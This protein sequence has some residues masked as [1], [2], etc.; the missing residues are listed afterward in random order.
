MILIDGLFL[1]DFIKL[2]DTFLSTLRFSLTDY[3]SEDNRHV[4][5]WIHEFSLEDARSHPLLSFVYSRIRSATERH[6]LK[7]E[8]SSKGFIATLLS[9]GICSFHTLIL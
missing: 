2:F 8:S 1:P 6:A 5:H 4:R 3:D 9:T 7:R